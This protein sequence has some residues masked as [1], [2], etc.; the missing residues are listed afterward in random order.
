MSFFGSIK[1]FF[2]NLWHEITGGKATNVLHETLVGINLVEPLLVLAV[3]DVDPEYA[4]TVQSAVDEIRKDMTALSDLAASGVNPSDATVQAKLRTGLKAVN[5]NISALLDA[6]HI[7]NT[8][9]RNEITAGLS[10]LAAVVTSLPTIAAPAPTPAV[11]P[12][13]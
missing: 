3:Q 6:G 9:L 8:N 12:T 13:Q 2:S 5:A 1:H 11:A 10:E 7:K 4:T